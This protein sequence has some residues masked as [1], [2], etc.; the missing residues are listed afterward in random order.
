MNPE[1]V[2]MKPKKCGDESKTRGDE[3]EM[4]WR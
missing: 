1:K 4:A 3:A 2:E